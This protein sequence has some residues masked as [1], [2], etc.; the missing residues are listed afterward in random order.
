MNR[1]SLP[2]FAHVLR[3]A[4]G[5]TGNNHE[6]DQSMAGQSG[7]RTEVLIVG[8]GI[9]GMTLGCALAGAGVPTTII[10]SIAP[11]N[12]IADSYDGR[13]TSIAHGQYRILSAIGLW[14]RLADVASPIN[15][16]RVAQGRHSG[17]PSPLYLHYDHRDLGNEAMGYVI[18]NR[19]IRK[20]LFEQAQELPHLTL[21]APATV[22][23]VARDTTSVEARLADGTRIRASL[24][25]AAD[26]R[27]SR[28]RKKAG[29][30]TAGHRYPQTSIVCTV[31][32]ERNHA[33]VAVELF[34][35]SGPFA[36]L[37]MTGRRTN[38]IWT[39]RNDLAPRFMAL[40]DAD[41]LEALERR[42]GSW[43]GKISLLPGRFSYPLTLQHALRYTDRRLALVG[44]A[45]HTIHPIA[46]QGLNMGLRDVA[47]L[48][49]AIIDARRLGLE[50]GDA[51]VLTRYQR[52]RY[53]D[54]TLLATVTDSLNRLFS[55][56][57]EALRLARGL[58]LAT[59]DRIPPLKRFLMRHAMGVVGDLPRLVRG[60]NL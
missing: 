55:N 50:A 40:D 6:A 1:I 21:L 43:L 39:E 51:T 14:P 2:F 20:A 5:S 16:I 32:H 8:G 52:W 60:E 37:P 48:A 12:T 15:D 26:G 25:V 59:V 46:G 56:E 23:D 7:N 17:D 30:R 42:F 22:E 49:E 58:G 10:D 34:L 57:S 24:A 19:L 31:A 18:E 13:T 9:A 41:F 36:M 33:G 53:F 38:I 11:K 4:T 44:D 29:I 28:L 54:N 27:N 47:A 35:P 3:T 45:A